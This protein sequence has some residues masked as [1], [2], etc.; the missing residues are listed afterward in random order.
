M[1]TVTQRTMLVWR[2]GNWGRMPHENH[3]IN[4]VKADVAKIKNFQER[5]KHELSLIAAVQ[6]GGIVKANGA[7]FRYKHEAKNAGDQSR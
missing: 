2:N 4:M 6:T 5:R 7:S 3:F 1:N